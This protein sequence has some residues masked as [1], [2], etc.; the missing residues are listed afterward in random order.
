MNSFFFS[1]L[2]ASAWAEPSSTAT[3]AAP[4]VAKAAMS[5]S[6][7]HVRVGL[8]AEDWKP[9]SVRRVSGGAGRTGFERQIKRGRGQKS[10]ARAS[11]RSYV[12]KGG[13]QVIISVYPSS[14]RL[15]RTHLEARFLVDRGE[16]ESA[17]VVAVTMVGG[18]ASPEDEKEDSV[19]LRAKGVDFLEESPAS[20]TIL[21]S[22][23]ASGPGRAANA[24][25]VQD[26]A[27]GSSSLGVVDFSWTLSQV[28]DR[29]FQRPKKR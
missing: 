16:L 20:G 18:I 3:V 27:F 22:A 17:S 21:L 25:R 23:L 4:V 12:V 28:G 1:I 5:S 26:A 2:A 14:L 9:V 6:R 7:V 19:T 8:D 10:T 11:A 24:G 15:A 29:S 13:K